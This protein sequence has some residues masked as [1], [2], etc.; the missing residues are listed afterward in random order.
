MKESV[1]TLTQL[2][3]TSGMSKQWL[4]K[5]LRE[6]KLPGTKVLRDGSKTAEWN[7]SKA[8]FDAWR[9]EIET[10]NAPKAEFVGTKAQLEDL[11]RYLSTCSPEERSRLEKLIEGLKA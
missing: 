7:I 3:R 11:Q 5:A 9:K 8:D 2:S 1:F 10:R 6:K 4:R